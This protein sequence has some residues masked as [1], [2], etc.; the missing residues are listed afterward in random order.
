MQVEERAAEPP[1]YFPK[2]VLMLVEVSVLQ[3]GMGTEGEEG[4]PLY[5]ASTHEF[6]KFAGLKSY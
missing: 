1:L 2:Q 3:A 5:L 6:V 4:F